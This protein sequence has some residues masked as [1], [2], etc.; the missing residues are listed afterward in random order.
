M[1]HI[2][3]PDEDGCRADKIIKNVVPNVGYVF[4]QKL[5]RLRKV[6]ANGKR[7][8]ASDRLREGDVVKI[9]ANLDHKNEAAVIGDNDRSLSLNR[10]ESGSRHNKETQKKLFEKLRSTIIYEDENFFAINKPSK[11]AVQLGTKVS[12]CVETFIKA[13]PDCKCYLTHRLDKDTSGVLLIAKNQNF[14]RK[15]TTL[16]RENK[17]KK[18]YLAVVEGKITKPGIV[19]GFLEKS[20]IGN[21]EKTRI[22]ESGQ[23]AITAYKPLKTIDENATLLELKPSTGR[24][25]QLRVHCAEVL[26]APILGDKKYN[27]NC[28]HKELFLHAY[29]VFIEGLGIEITAEPPE[30]F[31]EILG[32]MASYFPLDSSLK[33]GK[34][35]GKLQIAKKDA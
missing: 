21:E 3:T 31:Q 8:F 20:F 29:R 19:D 9:F 30:Y 28:R 2:V 25:H 18:T 17:I 4:L 23:R 5:F 13:R 1:E 27:K 11:L 10:V 12:V 22:A 14:A 33:N 6:K 16:F 7:I 26:N 24:K 15:L 35:C 34:R 32:D